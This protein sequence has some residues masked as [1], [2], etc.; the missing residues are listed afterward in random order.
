M[1]RLYLILIVAILVSSSGLNAQVS[2]IDPGDWGI[3]AVLGE[4]T[5]LNVKRWVMWNSAFDFGAGWSW[6]GEGY[7]T[8]YFDYIWHNFYFFEQPGSGDLPVYFGAGARFV[9]EG[10]D[11]RF[12]VRTPI[13]VEYVMYNRPL[14]FFIEIV[15]IFDFTPET[16]GNL[17]GGIGFRYMFR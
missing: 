15:P 5:A 1:R 16:E 11:V 10:D 7:F 8:G 6:K 2:R 9:V 13:G 4:P 12:G 14:S 3:G 17:S